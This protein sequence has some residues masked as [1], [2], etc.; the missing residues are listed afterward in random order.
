VILPKVASKDSLVASKDSLVASKDS[1]VASPDSPASP[2]A[3][4]AD[5]LDSPEDFLVV[6]Q[7]AF[8]AID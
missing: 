7:A 2:A 4:L 3:F 1:L 8:L 6:C 5:C